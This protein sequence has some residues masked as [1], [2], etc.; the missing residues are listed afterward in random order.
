[1][2]WEPKLDLWQASDTGPGLRRA[3]GGKEIQGV[4][5][6]SQTL[7]GGV[8]VGHAHPKPPKQGRQ[9]QLTGPH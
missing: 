9:P 7:G 3:S 4:H 1:M 6:E 2:L 8:A 5:A